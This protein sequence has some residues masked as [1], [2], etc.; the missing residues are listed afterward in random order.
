M[1]WYGSVPPWRP[2]LAFL[3][4]C[5]AASASAQPLSRVS[6]DS[7]VSIN[8][9]VGQNAGDRPDIVFDATASA[10]LGKGWTAYIRPW[11][12]Q[13][14]TDPYARTKEIYQAA[15]QYERNARIS[16]RVDLGYILSPIG[17]GLMD[18]RADTNPT[19]LP[20]LSYLG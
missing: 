2:G 15:V 18:M 5:S 14:S 4:A 3:V 6:V 1:S 12:R 9:F 17:L 20:H 13:A 16:T 10:R 19:I 11:L 8:Q 7:A